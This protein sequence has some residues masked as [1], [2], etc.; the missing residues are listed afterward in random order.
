MYG[1][2]VLYNQSRSSIWRNI[3]INHIHSQLGISS[4]STYM[5]LISTMSL[6]LSWNLIACPLC[7]F[8]IWSN[9][10]PF[11]VI[12]NHNHAHTRTTLWI[13]NSIYILFA[14]ICLYLYVI[15]RIAEAFELINFSTRIHGYMCVRIC[16]L[17]LSWSEYVCLKLELLSSS[18]MYKQCP[19]ESCPVR[20]R[21]YEI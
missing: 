15:Q 16:A 12:P 3:W 4:S 2:L 10:P 20:P 13:F 21:A 8:L 11:Q 6:S 1:W 19:F 7:I 9:H 18:Q 5:I 17:W 14:R